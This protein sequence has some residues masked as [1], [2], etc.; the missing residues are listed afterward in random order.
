MKQTPNGFTL[1]ENLVVLSILATLI[2]LPL[3]RIPHEM[4]PDYQSDFAAQQIKADLLLAQQVAMSSGRPTSVRFDNT[5][6]EYLIRFSF[7]DVYLSKAYPLDEMRFE[8]GSLG[9]Q[10]IGFLASGHPSRSGSF[11]IQAGNERYHF[12]IYLG[13]GMISYTKL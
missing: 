1:I 2:L 3:V 4:S 7:Y 9:T 11:I 12:T 8:Q 10:S 13:K 5:R 6:K